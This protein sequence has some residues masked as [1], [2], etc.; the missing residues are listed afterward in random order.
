MNE[1]PSIIWADNIEESILYSLSISLASIVATMA[2][3]TYTY[4]EVINVIS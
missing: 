4:L 3:G 2:V 1:W